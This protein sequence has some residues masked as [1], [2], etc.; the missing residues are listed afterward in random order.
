MKNIPRLREWFMMK[1]AVWRR[2]TRNESLQILGF[3]SPSLVCI[4]LLFVIPVTI[5]VWYSFMPTGPV[6]KPIFT[7]DNYLLM[8]TDPTFMALLAKSIGISLVVTTGAICLGYP[9]AYFLAFKVRRHQYTFLSVLIGPYLASYLLIL[10]AWKV[11]LGWSG[12]V[13]TLLMYVGLI[14]EPLSFLLYSQYTVMF[15]LIHIWGPWLI[16]PMFVSLEKIER[17]LLEASADLGAGPLQTFL[18]VTLPLSMPGVLVAVL[19][20]FIPVV[21]EFVTP[22][23]VGGPKGVMYG[24]QIEFTFEAASSLWPLGSALTTVMLVVILIVITLLLRE[25]SLDRIMESL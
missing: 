7:L 3:L 18:K 15:V 9:V 8:F 11:T 6:L 13:N 1:E 2:L 16:Y 20:V 23:V 4:M 5:L 17:P 14:K 24:N 25:V 10:F 12:V 19:F 21:G 22:V